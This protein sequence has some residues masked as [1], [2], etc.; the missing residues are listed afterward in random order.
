MADSNIRLPADGSGKRLDTESLDVGGT[1]VH[2]ERDQVA[3]KADTEIA[4]VRNTDPTA[5]DHGLV[6]RQA[7]PDSIQITHDSSASVAAGGTGDIDT[8]Q[9]NSSLTAK[10][11]QVVCAGTVAWKAELKTVTNAVESSTLH[12]WFGGP[13]IGSGDFVPVTKEAFTVAQ[14]AGAGLDAFRVTMTNLDTSEAADLYATF[15]YDEV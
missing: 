15:I 8:A 3:G 4:E 1:T 11:M 9:I 10:L 14:D 13:G 5:V 6:V 2:R 7:G 12:T